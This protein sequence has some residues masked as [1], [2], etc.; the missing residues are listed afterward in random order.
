[1]TYATCYVS[2]LFGVLV[3]TVFEY[4]ISVNIPEINIYPVP[5]VVLLLPPPNFLWSLAPYSS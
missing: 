2:S 1:M 4:L 5:P 3:L